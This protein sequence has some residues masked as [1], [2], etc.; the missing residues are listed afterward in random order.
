MMGGSDVYKVLVLTDTGDST[1][2]LLLTAE[3]LMV[4]SDLT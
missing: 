1:S 3:G 2:Q 4:N